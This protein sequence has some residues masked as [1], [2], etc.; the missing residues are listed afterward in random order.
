MMVGAANADPA[1]D[2]A[3][4]KSEGPVQP[5]KVE[6]GKYTDKDGTPTYRVTEGGKQVD[7]SSMSG[8]LRYN[9]NCIVCHGPDGA[10]S[11]YAP[12][13]VDALKHDDY[14]T[15]VGIVAGGKKDV[16]ASEQLVMPA[17]GENKNVMCYIDD[18][19]VYLRA[20]SD[21]VIGRGRPAEHEPKSAT[22]KKAEDACMG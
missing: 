15:F 6:D 2:A 4:L 20:R 11:T 5:T 12:S 14:A 1:P 9:A 19:Y 16:N 10:G 18:V 8:Y 7:W 13:L 22:F 17:F 3:S 21:G